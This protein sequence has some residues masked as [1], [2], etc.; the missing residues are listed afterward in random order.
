MAIPA[1][2]VITPSAPAHSVTLRFSEEGKKKASENLKFN[3]DELLG[4]VKRALKAKD[5]LVEQDATPPTVDIE[6]TSVR[7][8]SN[9]SAVM[10]GFMAGADSIEGN[11]TVS[12]ADGARLDAFKVSVSYALGGIGGG[13]DSARMDWMYEKFTEELLK[14]MSPAAWAPDAHPKKT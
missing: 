1:A 5:L 12:G 7:V 14:T 10:W 2:A 8:R 4:H 3:G 11:V 13:Q 6:I 9:F